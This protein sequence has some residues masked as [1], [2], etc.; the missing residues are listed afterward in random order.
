MPAKI[1]PYKLT[2]E[3]YS[4]VLFDSE[5]RIVDKI[6]YSPILPYGK[7]YINPTLVE[8]SPYLLFG[9]KSRESYTTH[10]LDRDTLV[11]TKERYFAWMKFIEKYVIENIE[12]E[13]YFIRDYKV[14][15]MLICNKY[16]FTDASRINYGYGKNAFKTYDKKGNL[17]ICAIVGNQ[18]TDIKYDSITNSLKISKSDGSMCKYE[19][20][21]FDYGTINVYSSILIAELRRIAGCKYDVDREILRLREYPRAIADE[22]VAGASTN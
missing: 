17:I 22:L 7:M 21:L 9:I 19:A 11:P 10:C 6:I 16:Y 5:N 12:G 14:F 20:L 8:I 2:D 13:D 15:D 18:H 3:Y 4:I 1:V